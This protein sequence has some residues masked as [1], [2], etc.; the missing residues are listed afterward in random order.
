[1]KN[2]TCFFLCFCVFMIISALMVRSGM[3]HISITTNTFSLDIS[4]E[5]PIKIQVWINPDTGE[6]TPFESQDQDSTTEPSPEEEHKKT[7]V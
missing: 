7:S 4:N 2:T 3:M 6:V 1:M 5:P